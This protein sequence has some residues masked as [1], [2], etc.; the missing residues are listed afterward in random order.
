MCM[1]IN[2]YTLKNKSINLY[3][4]HSNVFSNFK[5]LNHNV[6]CFLSQNI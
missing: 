2:K 6:V 5:F 1:K 4:T 3:Y